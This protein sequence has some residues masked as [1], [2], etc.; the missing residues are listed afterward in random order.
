MVLDLIFMIYQNYYSYIYR[1]VMEISR[2]PM[3]GGGQTEMSR[4]FHAALTML[5]HSHSL[6]LVSEHNS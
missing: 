6:K 5:A 2:N 4:W 3:G 1:E